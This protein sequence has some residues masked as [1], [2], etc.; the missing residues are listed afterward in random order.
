MR[1]KECSQLEV[2]LALCDQHLSGEAVLFFSKAT[3][4]GL[5]PGHST[6]SGGG[7]DGGGAASAA[8]RR[9]AGMRASIGTM[10][11]LQAGRR[12]GESGAGGGSP[13]GDAA[14][15]RLSKDALVREGGCRSSRS[16]SAQGRMRMRETEA[17][18]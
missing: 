7:D 13:A 1:E 16:S 5:V 9:W 2:L 8:K 15:S 12:R 3:L 18:T 10:S 6:G 17:A 11:R 14:V 4:V